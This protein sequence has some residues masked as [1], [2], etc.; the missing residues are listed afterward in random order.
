MKVY[1]L[2]KE[3]YFK[4]ENSLA[5]IVNTVHVLLLGVQ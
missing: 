4:H 2:R 1:P 5:L 3:F